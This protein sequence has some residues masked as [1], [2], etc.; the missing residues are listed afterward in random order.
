MAVTI[1]VPGDMSQAEFEALELAFRQH[2]ISQA[3]PTGGATLA[4]TPGY[5]YTADVIALMQHATILATSRRAPS[6]KI[7]TSLLLFS[8]A[9]NSFRKGWQQLAEPTPVL[10]FSAAL[11]KLAD[12][13]FDT[14]WSHYFREGAGLDDAGGT[15]PNTPLPLTPNVLRWLGIAN[16]KARADRRDLIDM[17]DLIEVLLVLP[18]GGFSNRLD[19]MGVAP[20]S[21]LS[22]YRRRMRE[23]PDDT[24]VERPIQKRLVHDQATGEDRMNFR[25]YA[26]AIAEFLN[27]SDTRGPVCISIQAP[28]GAGKSSLMQQVRERLDPPRRDEKKRAPLPTQVVSR[29]LNPR[30]T[31]PGSGASAT[32]PATDAAVVAA[33]DPGP[34]TVWFNAWKYESSEQVWAGLV[35]AVVSQVSERLG[36]VERELFLFRLNLARID[37]T[38][39]RKK[40]Y[41]K[42]MTYWW[43]QV[44]WLLAAAATLP[45]IIMLL[46]DVE[47]VPA[48]A[49]ALGALTAGSAWCWWRAWTK[50][51]KEPAK[52]TL[53]QYIRVP[54]Y[55][56]SVG[57]IHQIHKDLQHIISVLP[58]L[59]HAQG[60]A[61]AK[62]P[63][64]IFVDD[65]DRCTPSKVASVV[66]GVNMFLAGNQSEF[67]FVIG[68]D[69]Q[70][71]AAAL[72]HAHK[73]VKNQLPRYE[74]GAP[75]GWRFM[76]K[77]VQL[78]FTIPPPSSA[79]IEA[80]VKSLGLHSTQAPV[81]G[82]KDKPGTS[83]GAAVPAP[84]PSGTP[85]AARVATA[86]QQAISKTVT[87][88]S[89][90][91]HAVLDGITREFYCSPREIKRIMNFIRFVLLLRVARIA[92]SEPVPTLV[93]YQRWIMLSIRW[94]EMLRWL[95][96]G[97]GTMSTLLTTH[98]L[99]G[100]TAQRLSVLEA[101]CDG[102]GGEMQAWADA[103]ANQL[104]LRQEDV[105]WLA[106]RELHRFFIREFGR[107]VADRLSRAASIGFY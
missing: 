40:I 50:V 56:K 105:P 37:D 65:L 23:N 35:D 107:P 99:E 13:G 103:A 49:G 42:L 100:G 67:M 88:E 28:W 76:D 24:P 106:D 6:N 70:I 84:G 45:A 73:D 81:A 52:F 5:R 12:Q 26:V 91:V 17:A 39:V 20:T 25:Q 63:L 79:T 1:A 71:V 83:A 86:V 72:E 97:A 93:S 27:S 43:A 2:I 4:A 55:G 94:P 14:A 51:Q 8:I 92:N 75:L 59:P 78:A 7:S 89:E 30:K 44:R 19:E 62:M 60:E 48:S 69:P 32:P 3:S 68:M 53:A 46:P 34:W 66:E 22:E 102:P 15:T 80:F 87:E 36:V 74:Q 98:D 18:D 9:S 61:S 96:W 54:D 85:E 90:D 10:H 82:D 11:R 95:Q 21:L 64:V 31:S 101:A 16:N 58:D 29:F 41:D 104:G 33:R 38:E 77:F 57:I 47:A